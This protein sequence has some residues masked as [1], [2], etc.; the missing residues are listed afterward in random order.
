MLI[1][2][3]AMP[4]IDGIELTRRFRALRGNRVAPVLLLTAYGEIRDRLAGFEAGAVDYVVK[5]FEP[6]ELLARVRSQLALR[7]LTLQLV[8]SEK[9]AALGVLSTGLAHELRNPANGIVNAIEPLREL[10]PP[11]LLGDGPIG[12]LLEVIAECS[13]RVAAISKHLL[14]YRTGAALERSVISVDTLIDRVRATSQPALAGVELRQKLDYRGSILCVEPL[15]TQVFANLLDNAAYAAGRGGW[16]E[17]STGAEKESVIVEFADS[18]PG[19][20]PQLRERIFEPFFTTKPAGS[21]TGLGLA[22]AREI[23]TRHGGT[24]DVR[25][26]ASGSAVFRV[27]MPLNKGA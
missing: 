20:P 8:E 27:E 15:M 12:Q 26:S 14:G 17:I 2:D 9:L 11:E 13:V 3:V 16:V 6:A 21:G 10:L 19:V 5:P 23:V 4:G 18:G 22:T 24:L 7:T 1:T 25:Q